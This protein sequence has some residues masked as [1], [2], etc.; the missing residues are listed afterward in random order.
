M[1]AR[2]ERARGEEA[3][4]RRGEEGDTT[5]TT[6]GATVV[7]WPRLNPLA[8]TS[9]A[10]SGIHRPLLVT[11]T[12][13]LTL[14][15]IGSSQAV[16]SRH[17]NPWARTQLA[18]SVDD[19]S[20]HHTLQSPGPNARLALHVIVKPAAARTAAAAAAARRRGCRRRECGRA[21]ARRELR[22]E[23]GGR[24]G[25]DSILVVESGNPSF[26]VISSSFFP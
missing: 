2:A 7:G 18:F 4:R 9:R 14:R 21:H 8:D 20:S 24:G 11:T 23:G 19:F 25:D 26:C 10:L 17:T 12:G 22:K 13:D 16:S 1:R 3:K 6:L 5:A 15:H